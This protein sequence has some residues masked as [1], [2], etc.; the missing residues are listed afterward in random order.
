MKN[1]IILTSSMALSLLSTNLF[2]SHH[3]GNKQ[4]TFETNVLPVCGVM[5]EKSDGSI[6]FNDTQSNEAASFTV[7]TNSNKGH[8]TVSFNNINPSDNIT[9][10]EGFFEVGKNKGKSETIDWKNPKDFEVKHDE[11]QEI[12]AVV[13]QD[14]NSITSGIARVTTTLQVACN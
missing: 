1:K 12:L 13:P 14:S 11:E 2:A 3:G 9:N 10:K 8:A 4:I 6:K 5:I 7:K